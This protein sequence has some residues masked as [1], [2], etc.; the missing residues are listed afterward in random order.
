M[1]QANVRKKVEE[2]IERSSQIADTDITQKDNQWI[3][4]CQSWKVEA[5]NII[6]LAIPVESN[7]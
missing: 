2:L 1:I 6:Q 7:P 5:L 4:S 3:A